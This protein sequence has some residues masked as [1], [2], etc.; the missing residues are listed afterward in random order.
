MT[1]DALFIAGLPLRANRPH[2]GRAVQSSRTFICHHRTSRSATLRMN[3]DQLDFDEIARRLAGELKDVSARAPVAESSDEDAK[4]SSSNE[5]FVDI[6]PGNGDMSKVTL[7]HTPSAQTAEIYTYGACVTSWSTRGVENLWMSDTNKWESGGKAIRGGIPLCFPQ[8]GPYGDLVQHGFARI[9]TWELANTVR[10]E[11]DSVSAIFTLDSA[12]GKHEEIAKWG[13]DFIAE[14]TVTLSNVGLEAKLAVTNT[15][16]SPMPF[17]FAFHNYFKTSKV[18]DARLFGFE[19]L[20]FN[21]RLDGD[22]EMPASQQVEAGI[23]LSEETDRVYLSAPEELA[24]FDFATLRVLKIK[25][26]PTLPNATVW[27]PYGSDGCDPGWRDF[28]CIEPAVVTPGASV[29]P[30]ETWM[31]AQLLGVE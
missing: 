28:I 24:M 19:E 31:G 29:Q 1:L 21:N 25:K 8:F 18:D 17:T 5:K 22:R 23:L 11:D 27:N 7:S 26:T 12:T 16:A 13:Y 30:G 15:G 10:N 2:H 9:S 20:R 4:K 6:G 3:A 14:Y